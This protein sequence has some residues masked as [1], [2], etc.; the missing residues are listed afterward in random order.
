MFYIIYQTEQFN[1]KKCQGLYSGSWPMFNLISNMLNS[2]N[3]NITS[4]F[5]LK[6]IENITS[7]DNQRC[8]NFYICLSDI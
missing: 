1:C 6:R 8:K 5:I 3:S 4:N 2:A 7:V